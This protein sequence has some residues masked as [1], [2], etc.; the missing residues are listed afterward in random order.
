MA[1]PPHDPGFSP[2]PPLGGEPPVGQVARPPRPTTVTV[3]V[4]LMLIQAAIGVFGIIMQFANKDLIE[5]ANR[6]AAQDQP[7]ADPA[8]AANIALAVGT[9]FGLVFV[10]GLVVLALLNLRGNNVSRIITWVLAG[11]GVCCMG[12]G[13]ASSVVMPMKD[14]PGWFSAYMLV[15]SIVP[16]VIYI[17]I[18]VLLAL[19]ASNAYFK[20]KAQGQLY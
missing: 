7:G 4:A 17:A 8:M 2:P 13:S 6:A 5:R 3:A 12:I 20:P 9:V 15:G 11:F 14:V 19:P 18:I 10:I 1:N 16:L